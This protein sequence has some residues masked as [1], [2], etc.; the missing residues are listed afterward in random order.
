MLELPSDARTKQDSKKSASSDGCYETSKPSPTA[1]NQTRTKCDFLLPIQDELKRR[2]INF[3]VTDEPVWILQSNIK[4]IE[5]DD[6][7]IPGSRCHMLKSFMGIKFTQEKIYIA[8]SSNR[9]IFNSDSLEDLQYF[10]NFLNEVH[11]LSE[12]YAGIAQPKGCSPK[13]IIISRR[14]LINNYKNKIENEFIDEIV[15]TDKVFQMVL[16]EHL[17]SFL[18]RFSLFK[19]IQKQIGHD[20]E[21]ESKP[22]YETAKECIIKAVK[23]M[24]FVQE[25]KTNNKASVGEIYNI[26]AAVNTD[27]N[28]SDTDSG[29]KVLPI[30]VDVTNYMVTIRIKLC[31]NKHIVKI[32]DLKTQDAMAEFINYANNDLKRGQFKFNYSTSILCLEGNFVFLG[33]EFTE[34]Q[35]GFQDLFSYLIA[36]FKNYGEALT[37]V[38]QHFTKVQQGKAE[39]KLDIK[40]LYKN[41]KKADYAENSNDYSQFAINS[42]GKLP[43]FMIIPKSFKTVTLSKEDYA[44]ERALL[45][46]LKG[47]LDD[48]YHVKFNDQTNEVSYPVYPRKKLK[49]ALR[50]LDPAGILSVCEFIKTLHQKNFSLVNFMDCLSII[51][52]SKDYYVYISAY[53]YYNFIKHSQV[54]INKH[55]TI[56]L[57][58]QIMGE[59]F[60]SFELEAKKSQVNMISESSF[61]SI[62]FDNRTGY[63]IDKVIELIPVT[64]EYTQE[65]EKE[66]KINLNNVDSSIGFIKG[67]DGYYMVREKL[68]PLNIKALSKYQIKE[69]FTK[70]VSSCILLGILHKWSGVITDKDL[71][72]N[73]KKILKIRLA[74]R[75]NFRL[76]ECHWKKASHEQKIM[77]SLSL[78]L[79]KMRVGLEPFEKFAGICEEDLIRDLE[80]RIRMPIIPWEFEME[81]PRIAAYFK[82][83]WNYEFATL[84]AMKNAYPVE[85]D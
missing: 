3:R 65:V 68:E 15:S 39:S 6:M 81:N 4:N 21:A 71:L 29:W 73:S 2:N 56:S 58:R 45:I 41:T 36:N 30:S 54:G 9:L 34:I 60:S 18:M 25:K 13:T 55:E 52:K 61:D 44:Q 1:P 19:Q 80:K 37:N 5:G 24:G 35:A 20:S 64:Y 78:L 38:Y 8:T 33:L 40:S 74:N 63:L 82:S 12:F 28:S 79:Y 7:L 83:C 77:Y 31:K 26:A 42:G 66:K 84:E 85:D 69:Y 70:I 47:N 76:W 72:V 62:D 27:M 53:P 67:P 49:S 17:P 46:M 57:M 16:L 59:I 43:G 22:L 14:V 32:E 51:D 50:G 48:F 75:K 10:C 23:G 11:L